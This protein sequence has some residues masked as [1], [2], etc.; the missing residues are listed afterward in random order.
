L[1]VVELAAI[2]DLAGE[3]VANG[4]AASIGAAAAQAAVAVIEGE[5]R[6]ARL[7]DRAAEGARRSHGS[8]V[9]RRSAST[10]RTPP[11]RHV[12]GR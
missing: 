2:G 8:A 9:L 4:V 10:T 12:S 6:P 7:L 1:T 3:L 5:R 11:S